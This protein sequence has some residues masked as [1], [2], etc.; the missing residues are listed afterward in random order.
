MDVT[1]AGYPQG[2]QL[3][4]QTDTLGTFAIFYPQVPATAVQTI[5]GNGVLAGSNDGI[6]GSPVDDLQRRA[7]HVDGAGLPA[8]AA[9]TTARTTTCSCRVATTFCA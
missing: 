1:S 4:G 5:A 3:C 7:R 8:S 2:N 6:G 9:P